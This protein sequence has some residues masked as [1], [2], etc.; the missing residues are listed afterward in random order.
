MKF[1]AKSTSSELEKVFAENIELQK[2]YTI[3]VEEKTAYEE[4]FKGILK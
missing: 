1:Y 3:I 2:G 4:N